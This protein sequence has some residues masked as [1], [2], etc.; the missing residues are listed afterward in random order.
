MRFISSSLARSL[1][2]LAVAA[3]GVFLPIQ[4]NATLLHNSDFLTGSTNFNGFENT[5]HHMP[6]N[7][8][9]SEGGIDVTYVGSGQLWNTYLYEGQAGWYMDGGGSGYTQIK[10]SSGGAFDAIQFLAG[11]GF[12]NSGY[13]FQYELR[14]A[15]AVVDTGIGGIVGDPL[16]PYGFDDGIFDEVRLQ[17]RSDGAFDATAYEALA[18]D[19]I[20]IRSV[21]ANAVPE[22]STYGA[23]FVATALIAV[24]IRRFRR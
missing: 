10:L 12:G 23:L 16:S 2:F 18:L 15:G 24:G 4:V 21:N 19:N 20:Q 22:P 1:Q 6:S 9:Y 13:S 5:T 17:N 11:S 14:F 7:T 3:C 8:V